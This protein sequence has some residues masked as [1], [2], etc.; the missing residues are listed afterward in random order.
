MQNKEN[1]NR[2]FKVANLIKLSLINVFAKGKK[3]DPRLLKHKITI[4]NI[5]VSPDLKNASCYFLPFGNSAAYKAELIEAIER[6][7]HIIRQQV[8]EDINLKY[9]PELTFFY[10]YGLE[11]ASDVEKAINNF[12]NK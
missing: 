3:L 4:T 12:L 9:S 6:S 7:K 11:N 8:T 10:D 5:K 2:Q 1:S